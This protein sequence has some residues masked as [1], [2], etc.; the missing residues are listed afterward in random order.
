MFVDLNQKGKR[1]AASYV[2]SFDHADP[3][4]SYIRNLLEEDNFG[5]KVS[6]VD[7]SDWHKDDGSLKRKILKVFVRSCFMES[8]LVTVLHQ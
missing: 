8:K 4:N 6:E 2:N 5:I 7:Q 1:P 3:V